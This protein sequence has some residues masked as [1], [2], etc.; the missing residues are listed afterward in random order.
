MDRASID[1]R[2]QALNHLKDHWHVGMPAIT[3]VADL[4]GINRN[5]FKTRIARGQA[6]T[7]REASGHIRPTLIFTGYHLIYNL[8]SDRLLRYGFPVEHNERTLAAEPDSYARWVYEHVLS[9]PYCIDAVLK[10]SKDTEGQVLGLVYDDGD[11]RL[12][13]SDGALILPIG[14]MVLRVAATV[15][16][17]ANP[18]R[19]H[20]ADAAL[21]APADEVLD[22]R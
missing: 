5:T 1:L 19:Y 7:L 6:L 15:H 18:A 13:Y 20:V 4:L 10:F 9:A 17:L 14:H 16:M 2:V 12:P 11:T 3:S 22:T 21:K 8:L